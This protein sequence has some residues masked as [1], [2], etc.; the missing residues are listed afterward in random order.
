MVYKR[1]RGSI[2]GRSLPVLDFVKCPPP[3]LPG[4]N[5]IGK[6]RSVAVAL[7]PKGLQTNATDTF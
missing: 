1:V 4:V 7:S 3:P 5:V 2:S 6:V